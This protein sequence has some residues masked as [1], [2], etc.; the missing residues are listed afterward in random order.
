MVV[1]LALLFAYEG[2][3]PDQWAAPLSLAHRPNTRTLVAVAADFVVALAV[4]ILLRS[5]LFGGGN[6]AA[7]CLRCVLSSNALF[8]VSQLSF[9]GYLLQ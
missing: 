4:G 3:D 9:T 8:A 7:S 6:A 2:D 5:V 1:G